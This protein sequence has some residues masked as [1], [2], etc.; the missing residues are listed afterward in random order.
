MLPAANGKVSHGPTS[1][2]MPLMSPRSVRRTG[3]VDEG[4]SETIELAVHI[5]IEAVLPTY[6]SMPI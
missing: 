3:C 2:T 6:G 1:D 5:G 4:T